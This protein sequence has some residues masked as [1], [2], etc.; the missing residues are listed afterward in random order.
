MIPASPDCWS[1][2]ARGAH[3][4]WR[5]ALRLARQWR[6][7]AFDAV[8]VLPPS[9]RAAAVARLAGI[10]RRLGFRGEQRGVL[11]TDAL[12]RLPRCSRHYTEEL[13][14]LDRAWRG[15]PVPRCRRPALAPDPAGAC[16]APRS[17]RVRPS[18]SCPWARPTAT[19]RAGRRPPSPASS[20]WPPPRPAHASC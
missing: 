13:A 10:P 14:L 11:L 16:A 18:G 9:L 17:R 7:G 20:T 3:A 1:T 12:P 5:G 15:G 6:G 4:G 8:F 2:S 19:P